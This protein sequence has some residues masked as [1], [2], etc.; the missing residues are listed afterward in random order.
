MA[1][2]HMPELAPEQRVERV[3]YPERLLSTCSI[4]CN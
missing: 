3:G 4:G 1:V 2:T